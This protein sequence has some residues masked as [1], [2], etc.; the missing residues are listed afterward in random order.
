MTRS[1]AGFTLLE[2]MIATVIMAIAVSGVLVALSTSVRNASKLTDRDR[3]SVLARR[4]MEELLIE[5]RLPR[6]VILEGA[7][8]PATTNGLPSG[9]KARVTPFELPPNPAPGTKILDRIE[10]QIWW[11]T[12]AGAQ[13]YAVEGFRRSILAPEEVTAGALLPR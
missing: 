5:K 1:E 10:V 3:A 4:K 7:Y 13:T 12:S 9:W 6:H 8:D 11:Q 2:V